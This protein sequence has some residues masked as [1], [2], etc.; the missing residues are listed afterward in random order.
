MIRATGIFMMI[1]LMAVGSY[2][3]G[4]SPLDPREPGES[5]E[6]PPCER[7]GNNTPAH[8]T[9]IENGALVI[10]VV[11]S[12]DPVDFYSFYIPL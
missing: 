3:A 2:A 12:E 6:L 11:C 4:G 8:A 10:G 1:I 5:V 9:E 7:D